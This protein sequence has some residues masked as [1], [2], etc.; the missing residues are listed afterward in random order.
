MNCW[1]YP[2]RRSRHCTCMLN[3]KAKEICFSFAP[4]SIK[5]RVMYYLWINC[6]YLGQSFFACTAICLL[7]FINKSTKSSI[8]EALG[9][10]WVVIGNCWAIRRADA[11]CGAMDCMLNSSAFI[12]VTVYWVEKYLSL[13][14]PL[15]KGESQN[16]EVLK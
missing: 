5:N 4:A 2:E 10:C 12:R 1:G 6:C 13:L 7:Y 11:C 3:W 14:F 15:E 16:Y 9:G 8:T